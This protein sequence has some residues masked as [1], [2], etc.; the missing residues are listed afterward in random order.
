M[1]NIPCSVLIIPKTAVQQMFSK[2]SPKSSRIAMLRVLPQ[3]KNDQKPSPRC[4]VLWPR[5]ANCWLSDA[6]TRPKPPELDHGNSSL[7]TMTCQRLQ[8]K[9]AESDFGV[10]FW[11]WIICFI[12]GQ[13]VGVTPP[14]K[15]AGFLAVHFM[16]IIP[17]LPLPKKKSLYPSGRCPKHIQHGK[18]LAARA[19]LECRQAVRCSTQ[20]RAK[21]LFGKKMGGTFNTA[22]S[23]KSTVLENHSVPCFLG[24]CGWF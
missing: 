11:G 8:A 17:A 14:K 24:N 3:H 10:L 18:A 15:P 22:W 16:S 2:N 1:A 12:H 9:W 19:P 21:T 13:L 23:L 5:M 20:A 6:V 4:M 7:E